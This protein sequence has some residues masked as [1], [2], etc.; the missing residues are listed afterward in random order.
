MRHVGMDSE[1][2]HLAVRMPDAR[3]VVKQAFE[4][5]VPASWVQPRMF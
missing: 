2:W 1:R 4:H 3:S 5:A